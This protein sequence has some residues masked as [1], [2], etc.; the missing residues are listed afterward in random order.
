MR[1]VSHTDDNETDF[2][3][4]DPADPTNNAGESALLAATIRCD[5]VA[6]CT[7]GDCNGNGFISID[8]LV[9]GANIALGLNPL[10][11]CLS[12]DANGDGSVTIDEVLTAVVEA[13]EGCLL[14]PN[15]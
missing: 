14:P 2:A 9:Q 10:D 3:C 15:G 11:T 6:V 12:F 13:L 8:E 4:G 7:V 5:S 1:R